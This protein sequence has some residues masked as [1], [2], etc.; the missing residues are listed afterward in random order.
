M[1]VDTVARLNPL[2]LLVHVS[3]VAYRGHAI[4]LG[5]VNCVDFLLC[6]ASRALQM[7]HFRLW[8]VHEDHF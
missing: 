1:R 5:H 7:V 6:E 8:A 3:S 2:E 4:R